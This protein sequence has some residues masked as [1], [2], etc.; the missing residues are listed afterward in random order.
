MSVRDE[1]GRFTRPDNMDDAIR[2]A[3]GYSS[4]EQAVAEAG[5]TSG[6]SAEAVEE[7]EQRAAEAREEADR[8]AARRSD[9]LGAA[10]GHGDGGE[11][12]ERAGR[13][14][15]GMDD[16]IRS[17]AGLAPE[18]PGRGPDQGAEDVA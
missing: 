12:R 5:R 17:A 1:G 2:R 10:A 15:V 14:E 16:I 18:Y 9:E 11:G 3:A 13:R 4:L 6:I 8:L 7:A